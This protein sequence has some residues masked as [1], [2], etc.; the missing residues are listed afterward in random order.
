MQFGWRK[1]VTITARSPS[2]PVAVGLQIIVLLA[3]GAS[4]RNGTEQSL[5][6]PAPLSAMQEIRS[7]PTDEYA[8]GGAECNW[9]TGACN[10]LH[11]YL[12]QGRSDTRCLVPLRQAVG[13]ERQ[14][15]NLLKGSVQS[16]A[17][18]KQAH[19]LEQQRDGILAQLPP[20]CFAPGSNPLDTCVRI[21]SNLFCPPAS[22]QQLPNDH[23]YIK[24][25]KYGIY[26]YSRT[27]SG[28]QLKKFL[29]HANVK[30]VGYGGYQIDTGNGDA[31]VNFSGTTNT[32]G[33]ETAYVYSYG[34]PVKYVAF[35]RITPPPGNP[36]AYWYSVNW[37]GAGPGGTNREETWE[38]QP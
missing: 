6:G 7:L 4:A 3:S 31:P 23:G 35:T 33:G 26:K 36:K 17:V 37:I 15:Q 30:S 34:K 12:S 29:G 19:D 2:L 16:Y 28:R 18:N 10:M 20:D 24:G 8:A 9:R 27:E 5:Q 38:I 11:A 14:E 22:A 13:L 21:F 1:F 32:P 25:G